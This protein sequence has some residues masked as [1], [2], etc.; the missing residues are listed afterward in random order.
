MK[1]E[2]FL[3][4]TSAYLRNLNDASRLSVAVGLPIEKVGGK[5]YK[6]KNKSNK[7][8]PTII[9]V[10]ASHEYGAG[11]PMRSF[12]RMPFDVERKKMT[13]TIESQFQKVLLNGKSARAA[14][15][16]IGAQARNV[17]IAAFKTGGFGQWQDITQ[18][19]KDLK[20]SS[21]I[22]VNTST[23]KGAITWVVR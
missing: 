9:E 3:K 7:E 13:N 14:L 6:S 5:V 15:G 22:L 4:K 11:V 2:A 17:V 21:K 18:T 16:I 23:L 8:E 10:G 12:L 1:P 19:T 20:G